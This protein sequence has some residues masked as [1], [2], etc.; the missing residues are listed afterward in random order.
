MKYVFFLF[1]FLVVLVS[2][3]QSAKQAIV[4]KSGSDSS[5]KK[6]P[7]GYKPGL[8]EFM[9]GVQT[10]H[11]KL[12]FAGNAENWDLAKF[13]MDETREIFDDVKLYCSD[14]K[15]LKYLPIIEPGLDSV[16][17]AI[18]KKNLPDFK[19]AYI[20]MTGQ[21]NSC[22]RSADHGFNVIVVPDKSPFPDQDFKKH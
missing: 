9:L 10:H 12:W 13:E 19:S 15:E 17:H 8:G 14:R 1:F 2:C 6:I 16:E 20:F 11:V 18:S 22:H 4:Q 21:C 7:Q 3:E 5:E